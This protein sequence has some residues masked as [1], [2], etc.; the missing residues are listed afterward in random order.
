MSWKLFKISYSYL[1]TLKSYNI[2]MICYRRICV[3]LPTF[4]A[5][6][7][8]LLFIYIHIPITKTSHSHFILYFMK[9]NR[10]YYCSLSNN[11]FSMITPE[12]IFSWLLNNVSN[13]SDKNLQWTHQADS[14]SF[15]ADLLLY[16]EIYKSFHLFVLHCLMELSRIRC[17]STTCVAVSSIWKF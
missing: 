8:L 1:H 13:V 14:W 9:Y 2:Y 12:E 5:Y 4:D 3:W 7:T 6:S 16:A 15:F 11:I 17:I 10:K